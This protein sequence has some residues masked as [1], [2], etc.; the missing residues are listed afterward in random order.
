[1]MEFMPAVILTS[2]LCPIGIE[3]TMF[4]LLAGFQNFGQVC[5]GLVG[6]CCLRSV[7][8]FQYGADLLC[9]RLCL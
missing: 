7:C 5:R 6:Q 9:L 8:R 3:A 4:A 2:K 1:M